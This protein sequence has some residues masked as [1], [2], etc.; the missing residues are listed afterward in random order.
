M[1]LYTEDRNTIRYRI[2]HKQDLQEIVHLMSEL[3]YRTNVT[4][5]QTTLE[6]IRSGQGEV[7]VAEVNEKVVGCINAIID[8]R[9]AEGRTGEIV[10]LVVN[11]RY[12]GN[13]IGKGLTEYAEKWLL[14]RTNKIRI[15]ANALREDAHRFYLGLG[16]SE[17]KKQKVFTKE[18]ES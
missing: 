7:F 13:G 5:L 17:M 16:Y 11:E 15:R 12:R 18:L 1:E 14:T 6:Q 2:A 10:S 3:G 8:V 9:L 4:D